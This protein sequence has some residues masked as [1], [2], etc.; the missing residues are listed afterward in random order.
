[1]VTPTSSTWT[2]KPDHV[3][4]TWLSPSWSRD[5]VRTDHVTES[6]LI[7]WLSP[8]WS[9]DWVRTYYVTDHVTESKLITWLIMWLITWLSPSW[10]RDGSRPRLNYWSRDWSRGGS[11]VNWR[12]LSSSRRGVY[13]ISPFY[14]QAEFR[15]GP[16]C[17]RAE[18][19]KSER[20]TRILYCV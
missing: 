12:L 7:R 17:I 2:I 15:K 11:Q 6:E 16:P 19:R 10:S 4:I 3:W 9:R 13:L 8:N 18:L 5:W 20:F 14:T 1:M